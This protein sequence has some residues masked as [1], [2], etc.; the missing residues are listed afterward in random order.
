[1]CAS[2][3]VHRTESGKRRDIRITFLPS[4]VRACAC[5][6]V[7]RPPRR[8][9]IFCSVARNYDITGKEA[10]LRLQKY[11]YASA[12]MRREYRNYSARRRSPHS[13]LSPPRNG[14]ERLDSGVSRTN[15]ST[16][17]SRTASHSRGDTIRITIQ[18]RLRNSV[19]ELRNY[20]T[21]R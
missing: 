8:L 4:P 10:S 3:A 9:Y 21:L 1:M 15:R 6:R 12:C 19:T 13:P 11:I 7:L 17:R 18:N 20:I 5:V 16:S 2:L 14:L